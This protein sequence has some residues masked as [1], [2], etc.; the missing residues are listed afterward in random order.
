MESLEHSNA[1]TVASAIEHVGRAGGKLLVQH[2]D[3]VLAEAK[4]SLST[5]LSSTLSSIALVS[6]GVIAAIFGWIGLNWALLV[7]LEPVMPRVPALLVAVVANALVATA[8][9]LMGVKRHSP[10]RSPELAPANEETN[11][12]GIIHPSHS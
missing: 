5:T 9:I 12:N 11:S 7:A 6:T 10:K 8:L 4:E 2:V 3:L 1:T